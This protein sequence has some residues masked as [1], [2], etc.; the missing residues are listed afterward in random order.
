MAAALD[1]G[2]IVLQ[3]RLAI[4]PEEGF[5][6]LHDRLAVLGAEAGGESLALVQAGE[7][8]RLRQPEGEAS[9]APPIRREELVIDWRRPAGVLANLVRALSPRPGARTTRG[10]RLLKVLG[11]REGKNPAAGGGTPG[12]VMELTKEGFWVMAGEGRLL[13]VRVQPAGG[14]AMAA[15]DY[16]KGNRLRS[17]ELLGA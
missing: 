3:R 12:A 13:V 5:G 9:Y 15:A 16:L 17:G 1:A 8:P 7:A 4:G 14:R 10:G 6:S 2:D 11:A